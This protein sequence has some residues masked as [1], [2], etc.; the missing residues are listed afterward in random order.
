VKEIEVSKVVS[1]LDRSLALRVVDEVY[2]QEKQWVAQAAPEI[3]LD[4]AGRDDQSWFLVAVE[5]EPAG[6]IRLLY[7]PPLEIPAELGVTLEPGVD[8]E[9]LRRQGRFA[10]IGRFMILPEHRKSIRVVLSLMRGAI[11]EVVER[12]YTHFLTDVF[13]SD[14]HSPLGFHTRVLG[15]ERIATH[16]YGDLSCD[17]LR[18]VLVLD[19]VRSLRRLE[20]R[21][22]RIWRELGQGLVELMDAVER[23]EMPLPAA[24]TPLPEKCYRIAAP[25]GPETRLERLSPR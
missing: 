4:V 15:F 10:E 17:S 3:P 14:P 18:I 6:V 23:G 2:R 8:L 12:R 19:I 16:R 7:D 9:R 25:Q 22:D 21:Q 5:G 11:R 1:P 13:E 20:A 24:V